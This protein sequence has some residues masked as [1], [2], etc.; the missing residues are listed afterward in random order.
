MIKYYWKQAWELLKQHKLFSV[1]YITGAGL[2]IAMTMVV[3][4]AHYIRVAPVYPETNR[5]ETWVLKSV[6]VQRVK[7]R[8]SGSWQSSHQLVRDWWYP[9][10]EA[11]QVSAVYNSWE[12]DDYIQPENLGSELNVKV[13]YTDPAFFRIF[14]FSFLAGKPFSQA[15]FESGIMNAVVG[16][17]L[18]RRLFGTTE[19]V[20]KTFSLNYTDCRI[21]GV[22]KDA[23]F[24]TRDSFAQLYLP[25]TTVAGYDKDSKS[26][27]GMLGPYTVYFK[28]K[29]DAMGADLEA[30]MHEMVRKYNTSQEEN[31]LVL[32]GPDVYW[33]SVYRRGNVPLDWWELIRLWGGLVLIFLLVPAL[34][35]CAMISTRMENRLPEM[36]ICKAFGADRGRLLRQILIENLILTCLGGLLGLCWVWTILIAG[37]NWVFTLFERYGN[38]APEG[39]DTIVSFDMLFSPWIF[40]AG[41]IVCLLLN[42]FSALWPAWKA[43][44]KDIVYSLNQ[45]K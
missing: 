5:A 42:L 29:D 43:L 44:G 23:S 33:K 8:G 12:L 30:A 15:D 4:V 26:D 31:K 41:F 39:V 19:V 35:L 20:G 34:N 28:V 21:V 13:K 37:R 2:A 27:A 14:Q 11:E 24:L 7:T 9:I 32:S 45:K 18:A 38:S 10:Q 40:C 16:E 6:T 1:L 25:Y 17:D 22:V 3:F 36:G